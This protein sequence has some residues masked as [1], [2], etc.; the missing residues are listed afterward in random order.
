MANFDEILQSLTSL[1]QNATI[2]DAQSDT[3]IIITARRTFEMAPD[4]DLILGYVGDV[5]SQVV[6]FQFPKTHE[7][8]DLS[9]CAFKKIK[10][11]NLAS[12]TEGVSE[13]TVQ[14]EQT[15]SWTASW[16]VPPEIMT[17]SGQV[18][19]AIS[20]YDEKNGLIAFSWNTPAFRE[21]SVGKTANQIAD[22]F[23]E[24][25][26]PANSEIL[27]VNAETRK[28]ETPINWNPIVASFGD[29][30]LS[31]VFFEINQYI[32]GLDLLDKDT[33]IYAGVAFISDTVEDFEITDVRPLFISETNK[34]ANKVLITWDIPAAITNNNQ[35]YVGTFAISLKAQVNDADGNIIK[36]WSTAQFDKLTIG[37][38]VLLND[39]TELVARDE[40]ILD[41]AVDE[42]V[43]EYFDN[44]YMVFD[45]NN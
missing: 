8:H 24:N 38:S 18:E 30:G 10:W 26:L 3:P 33:K 16:A 42:K 31:K 4:Y 29:I 14:T 28:I 23:Q 45:N 5:N 37:P 36:R 40:E 39:V 13:L 20:I 15:E 43:D 25:S 19:I 11:Q 7:G 44:T 21:F 2:A 1:H 41:R 22:V 35:G 27:V 34:K 6:T 12:G 9:K 32:R 17:M